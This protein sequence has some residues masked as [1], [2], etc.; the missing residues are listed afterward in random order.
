MTPARRRPAR[1]AAVLRDLTPLA[2]VLAS[3]LAAP[4]SV[5][6]LPTPRGER[7]EPA[8]LAPIARPPG[9]EAAEVRMPI[10]GIT[11]YRSGVG[12]FERRAMVQ[13]AEKVQLRFAT[14][15]IN[16]ILK[17]MVI[18][19]L[20]GG[21]IDGVSY[22]SKDPLQR[23]LSSFG[24]DL[25]DQP[26]L[27]TILARLRGAEARFTVSDGT[28]IQGAILGGEV[29]P[30]ASG[31]AQNPIQTPYVNVVTESGIRSVNLTKIT[32]VDLLDKGL[33]A[34]LQKALA[35]LAEHH[36]DR[37]KMVEVGFSGRGARQAIIAYVHEMPV[38]K[39]SYRLILPEP[40]ESGNQRPDAK[41]GGGEG[42]QPTIQGWAIV[43]NTTDEDWED[44]KLSLVAGRPVSFEMDLYEPLHVERPDVPVPMVAGAKP[45]IYQEGSSLAA[46]RELQDRAKNVPAPASPARTA[47][48][49]ERFRS[50]PRIELGQAIDGVRGGAAPFEEKEISGDDL[51]RYAAQSQAQA[52][53]VGEVFQYQLS[54]PVSISRQ[55]SAMLPILSSAIDG[56]RVSIYNRGDNAE[57]PMR[58]VELKNTTGLQLMPGPISVFDGPAYAGDAQIGHVTLGDKRLLAYAVDLDVHALTK[59]DSTSTVR[60]V[61]IAGGLIERTLKQESRVSYA[62]SNKDAKRPRTVLVE[63]PKVQNWDLVEPKKAADETDSLYRFE[64][65]LAP[66]EAGKVDVVQEHTALHS[67]AVVGFDLPTLL[68]Y[69]KQG[70]AS[71]KVLEAVQKAA[72][73][74]AAINQTERRIGLL[75]Q[76]RQTIDQDQSRIRQNMANIA[77]DTELYRRYM[78]KLNEQETRLEAIR[79]ER[80]REE[81]TLQQQRQEL[82]AYVRGLNVE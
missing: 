2:L 75:D 27:G 5:A 12:Y 52:G 29:R 13:D 39:T 10:R 54:A 82:E 49:A 23:R 11:L 4:A 33:N 14:D 16:D 7:N 50:V 3:G 38:W 53:D 66:S 68:G 48:D 59:H 17:S 30:E 71:Q 67:L 44:V 6:Q 15:Q 63:H 37:T 34:E 56:R 69:V 43:E 78:T 61:R 21:R 40:P 73:M 9:A 1:A 18:L 72:D 41:R 62:F 36:A 60:K 24:I 57:H 45:K 65:A 35:A 80:A 79:E 42:G 32:A 31:N 46:R 26:P 51:A 25:S 47:G 70:K 28:V 76:E 64:V 74:Q 58:G 81:G 55:R 19:D 20:D 77:R 22:G 8:R